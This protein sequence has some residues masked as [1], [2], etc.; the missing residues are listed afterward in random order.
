[1]FEQQQKGKEIDFDPLFL[2]DKTHSHRTSARMCM[3]LNFVHYF[4][5]K[6]TMAS[7]QLCKH[8]TYSKSTLNLSPDNTQIHR[9]KSRVV[10]TFV[11]TR[12]K[13][14]GVNVRCKYA[15]VSL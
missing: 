10:K 8:I 4:S 13:Q 11:V 6:N 2:V 9:D 14:L 5:W 1:M 15:C 7:K 12:A 3:E